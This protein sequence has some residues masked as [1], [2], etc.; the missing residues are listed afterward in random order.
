LLWFRFAKPPVKAYWWNKIPNFGDAISPLIL[1]RFAE[2]N[3]LWAS[4]HECQIVS[5]G[6]VLEHLPKNFTGYVV[7]T[8][9]LRDYA[10]TQ[11]NPANA[12]I[13]ALR[14]PLSAK[15]IWGNYALG[16]PGLLA[17]ELV[18]PQD[19]RW[20]LSVLPHWKD[21]TLAAR[22][23]QANVISPGDHPLS[24][25]RDIAASN[26]IVTSSLHGMIVADA[27]AIPR[28]VEI[29]KEL[30]T[31]GSWFKFKDYSLSIRTKFVPGKMMT[32]KRRDVEDATYEIY[33]AMRELSRVN[34]G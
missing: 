21:K 11:F 33:D 7:G 4:P 8:G 16:D 30:K 23:P 18:E 5:V 31:E 19:K 26:R 10:R 32:P 27:F 3:V 17:N 28:R 9:L 6:S 24:V 14:G 1:A 15:G 34:L 22:F 2:L 12:K 29:C 13:L 20:L 25:I